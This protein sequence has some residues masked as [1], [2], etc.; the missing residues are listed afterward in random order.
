MRARP[1]ADRVHWLGAID[2][3]R[4]LFDSLIPLPEGTSYNAYLVQGSEKT[5]LFDTVD[6]TMTHVLMAQLEG[7]P[8]VDIVVAHHG[9]QDHSGSIPTVLERYPEATLMCSPKAKGMLVDHLAVG[10]DRIT[11]VEDGETVSLGD[12]TLRFVHTPWVHWPETM[13]TYLEEDRVLFSCDFFGSHLATS[14]LYGEWDR[15][16]RP[17]KRYYAEIMMP[18]RRTIVRNLEK[19]RTLAPTMICPSHGPIHKEPEPIIAAYEDWAAGEPKNVVVVPYVSMHGSTK[20]M[21]DHFVAALIDRGV[22]VEQLELSTVD[23]GELA[24]ALVDAATVVLGTP[25]V[26][27]GPHP[28]VVQAAYLAS[29]LKPKFRWASVIGSYGWGSKAVDHIAE[30]LSGLKPEI[31]QPVMCKGLPRAADFAALDT[32]AD[33]IAERHQG[34]RRA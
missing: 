8:S 9:E 31:L 28:H 16:H 29:A 32:L 11:T 27:L 15:V 6:P 13:V 26:I 18:F 22:G 12:Q 23:L 7:V 34:L 2:W 25:T 10:E 24:M 19:V 14:D 5:V 21:V 17:A 20:L 4:R 33:A 1:I 3:D 30:A